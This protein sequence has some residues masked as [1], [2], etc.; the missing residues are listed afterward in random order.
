MEPSRQLKTSY[1]LTAE[2]NEQP[3]TGNVSV[4]AF[5][6][7]RSFDP[8]AILIPSRAQTRQSELQ[9]ASDVNN[10][11]GDVPR[12]PDTVRIVLV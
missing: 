12:K 1:V 2:V 6:V 7:P 10:K 5:P 8:L 4:A 3:Q 11:N 9:E